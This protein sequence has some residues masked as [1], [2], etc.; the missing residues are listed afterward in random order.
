MVEP[1]SARKVAFPYLINGQSLL[2]HQTFRFGPQRRADDRILSS[3]VHR[4]R[5]PPELARRHQ[6]GKCESVS[7]VLLWTT[8]RPGSSGKRNWWR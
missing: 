1:K 4:R 8:E 6:S 5:R 3:G 2:R 7:F